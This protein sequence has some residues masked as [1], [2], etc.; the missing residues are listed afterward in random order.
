MQIYYYWYLPNN[1]IETVSKVGIIQIVDT[2]YT[3]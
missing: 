1:I 3:V 2:Q